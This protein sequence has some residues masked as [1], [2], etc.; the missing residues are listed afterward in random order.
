MRRAGIQWGFSGK[1]HVR[2]G[3]TL[4]GL[5]ASLAGTWCGAIGSIFHGMAA[6]SSRH[7]EVAEQREK[8]DAS[9]MLREE[10]S[11]AGGDIG[12]AASRPG[13]DTG[14][15]AAELHSAKR[16]RARATLAFQRHTLL[17]FGDVRRVLDPAI[18]WGR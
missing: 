2:E 18:G 13:P 8:A 7:G 11:L 1:L 16:G 3:R 9:S 12:F 17:A 10:A 6:D 5:R 14:E 15:T 4:R